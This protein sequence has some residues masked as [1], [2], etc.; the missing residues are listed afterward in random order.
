M[1]E[2]ENGEEKDGAAILSD[3]SNDSDLVKGSLDN[4]LEISSDL[5]TRHKGDGG[6]TNFSSAGS[7][8][9]A[10]GSNDY[11]RIQLPRDAKA[12]GS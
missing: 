12:L 7:F 2:G 1:G 10:A 8:D 4:I 9:G 11:S 3:R 6:E 5:N